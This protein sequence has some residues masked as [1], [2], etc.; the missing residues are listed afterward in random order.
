VNIV[1]PRYP[2]DID[3]ES[4]NRLPVVRREELD[5]QGRRVFDEVT[6]RSAT[7]IAGLQGPG[8]IMLHSPALA[9]AHRAYNRALRSVPELGPVLT[10]LTILV[11][12]REM[13]QP[14]EWTVHE[15]EA[16]AAG[17]DPRT[18]DVV[19][20]RRPI[21]VLEEREAIVIRLGRE[22]FRD[23]R[24]DPVTYAEAE[25][26]FGRRALVSLTA[27]MAAYAGTAV[28]LTVFDQQLPPGVES[29]LPMP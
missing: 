16:L 15:R 11:A 17:L 19:R 14:F 28:L 1:V 6:T 9:A 21:E 26:L 27:I 22:V 18:I 13:S 24:V 12:A 4:R 10:E 7:S 25:R 5:E 3:P 8:G 2:Q 23:R 20:H 29:S